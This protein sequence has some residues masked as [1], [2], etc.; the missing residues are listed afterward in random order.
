MKETKGL[1]AACGLIAIL[2]A[3][4]INNTTMDLVHVGSIFDNFIKDT[5]GLTPDEVGV[6]LE[7]DGMI[8]AM[9][10][11]YGSHQGVDEEPYHHSTFI[12]DSKK[13]LT[14]LDGRKASAIVDV[15]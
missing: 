4:A 9:N 12:A 10:D 3:I 7:R 5:Q 14:E 11:K 6:A 2:H 8:K 15:H 1:H 13:R